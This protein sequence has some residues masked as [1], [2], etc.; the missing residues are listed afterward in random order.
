MSLNQNKN[1][2]YYYYFWLAKL[3]R[4]EKFRRSNLSCDIR[5]NLALC[6]IFRTA[7]SNLASLDALQLPIYLPLLHSNY[8]ITFAFRVDASGTFRCLSNVC[9]YLYSIYIV[10]LYDM[11]SR[12]IRENKLCFTWMLEP[13]RKQNFSPNWLIGTINLHI[14][15]ILTSLFYFFL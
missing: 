7:I 6:F 1:I 2:L 3:T 13:N 11:T 8:K 9:V 4:F 10:P 14:W 12:T 15:N 5:V